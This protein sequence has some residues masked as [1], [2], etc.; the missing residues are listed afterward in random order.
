MNKNYWKLQ[1]FFQEIF[2]NF[3]QQKNKHICRHFF[4]VQCYRPELIN[5][6][7]SFWY[8]STN[9]PNTVQYVSLIKDFS[10]TL[11]SF[12]QKN[13]DVCLKSFAF[14]FCKIYEQGLPHICVFFVLCFLWHGLPHF[15]FSVFSVSFRS[16]CLISVFF[17]CFLLV[18]AALPHL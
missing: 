6:K 14:L 15:F 10:K 2:I 17:L 7:I 1:C 9:L 4:G 12:Q 16:A 5:E 18:L 13:T 11:N 3:Q 8:G